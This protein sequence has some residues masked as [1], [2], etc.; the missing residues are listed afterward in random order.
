MKNCAYP[1]GNVERR[2]K[3]GDWEIKWEIYTHYYIKIH[4]TNKDQLYMYSTGNSTQHCII[5]YGGK[6]ASLV[7]QMIKNLPAMQETW[8]RSLGWEDPLDKAM[9]THNSILAWR[10]PWT[11]KPGRLYSPWVTK[12][13]T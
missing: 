9:A 7:A 13:W 3:L 1:R 4:V 10:M 8:V 11:E 2:D 5:T 6:G 12:N